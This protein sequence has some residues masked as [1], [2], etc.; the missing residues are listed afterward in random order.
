MDAAYTSLKKIACFLALALLISAAASAQPAFVLNGGN[1]AISIT[2]VGNQSTPVVVASSLSPTTEI[3]FTATTTYTTAGDPAWLCIANTFAGCDSTTTTTPTTLNVIVG[4]SSGALSLGTHTATITLA[5]TGGIAGT[6]MV[7]YTANSFQS[8]GGNGTL[9]ANPTAPTI[10]GVFGAQTTLFFQLLTT[11]ASS[12]SFSLA[13]PSVPW[14]SNFICSGVTSGAVSSGVPATCSVNLNGAGQAETTLQTTLSIAYSGGTLNVTISF[15]NGVAVNGSSGGTGTL[16]LST[17]PVP[18][19]YVSNSGTLPSAS[20]ILSSTSG[21][22]SYSFNTQSTNNWLLINQQTQGSF[23]PLPATLNIA[24]DTNVGTLPAGI[25]NGIVNITGSDGST[26]TLT[27]TVTV[28]GTNTSGVTISPNP[29]AINAAVN[30]AAVPQVVTITSN[31]GGAVTASISGQGLTVSLPASSSISAGGSTSVTVTGT[32]TGLA[33]QTYVGQLTV[34]VGGATQSATVNFQVGSTSGGGGSATITAAPAAMS[35]V[36]ELNSGA[37]TISQQQQAYVAGSGSYTAVAT[38]N[39]GSNWLS[40]SNPSGVLPQT[41]FY[42][43]ANASGLT[44]GTYLGTVTFTNTGNGQT[45]VINVTLLVIGTT[46]IYSIPGDEVFA[47]ISGTTNPNF[48]GTISVLATDSSAVTVNAAVSNPG[49]TP[50]LTLTSSSV[51]VTGSALYTVNVNANNLPNGLYT[52]AIT[53]TGLVNN[54]PLNV[55]VVLSVVGSGVTSGSGSLTL[56]SSALTLPAQVNGGAVS[57]TLGVT[58]TAN[59]TYTVTSQG[60]FNGITWLSVSPSGTLTTSANPNLTVTANPSNFAAGNYAGTISLTAN[61][62]TQTVQVTMTIGGTSGASGNVT[63][64]ANGGTSTSPTL[65]FSSTAPGTPLTAQTLTVASTTGSS[66]VGFQVTTSTTSGGNWIVVSIGGL[67]YTTSASGTTPATVNVNVNTSS[68]SVGT[69]N[70]SVVVTPTGGTAVTVPVTLTLGTATVGVSQTTLSFSYAAGGATPAAQSVNVTLSNANVTG[71]TFTATATSTPSGW[72][73][74]N[75]ASGTAPGAVTVSVT[76]T[77]LAAGTY[78]GSIAVS[79]ASGVTGSATIAVTLTVTVPLPTVTAV[80]NAASFVNGAISPG[81]IISIFGT[82]IGPA[83]PASLTLDSTGKFVSTTLSGVQVQINGYSAPLTYVSSTQINAVVPYEIAGIQSPMLVV[84]TNVTTTTQTSNGFALTGAATAAGIF[85]QN[86]SGTGPGAIL[87]SDSV[88]T[89][90]A[91]HPASRGTAVVVY[92]TGEGQTS[93]QG[94]DGKVTT[95][96]YPAPL[97][98]VAVTIGGQP[99]T[100]QFMGEAPGFVSGVLQLNVLIPT[101]LTTTGAVPIF[102]AFG[103]GSSSQAGVTVN[104]Q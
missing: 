55:P 60:S 15:G 76:P 32:P 11:S 20:V 102:V 9:S 28:S 1:N 8:G 64:T 61:G 22:A 53:I 40:V 82:N 5:G 47:Y 99:A 79:G 71:G 78:S 39:T 25:S 13:Q 85:T 59:T 68:L 6:I 34:T 69:Y 77:G 72:L 48:F 3:A 66:G 75:P 96:P 12:V 83:T 84:R 38:T 89:N 56:G 43:Y 73:A 57:T 103:G 10:T 74:V 50:W 86:G 58:A 91:A 87:N 33:A 36:Y 17:N 27:V 41:F 16:T 21:A 4:Q 51:S 52:G 101:S 19:S 26:I 81:E 44:A 45:S 62:I 80:T 70:G 88:T 92:M 65:T 54:S 100:V 104:I 94:I 31:V 29:V 67:G 37:Q 24:A 2:L 18:L 7:Q 46:G 98:P 42:V 23:L 97:L 35:F 14:A 90:S 30:G 63:V 93:P 95:A 49:N